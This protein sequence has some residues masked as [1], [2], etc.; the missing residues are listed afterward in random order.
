MAGRRKLASGAWANWAGDQVCRPAADLRPGSRDELAE[1]IGAAA[2][3]GRRVSVAG[4]GHSFTEAALTTGTMLH[5]E[6]LAGVLDA[7]PGSGLV[8]VGGGT[9][10]AALN[11]EL[12]RLGLA[13]ENLGDIDVQTIAGSDPDRDPRDRRSAAQP[14]GPGRGGRAGPG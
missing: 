4:S 10:L 14:L 7:D 5:V 3:A 8:R 6:S 9:V 13:M 1:A 12:A 11:E 2:A